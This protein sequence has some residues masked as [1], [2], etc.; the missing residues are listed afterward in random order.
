MVIFAQKSPFLIVYN[1]IATWAKSFAHALKNLRNSGSIILKK[2]KYKTILFTKH[3]FCS[4][5]TG[6]RAH[7]NRKAC[8]PKI[9]L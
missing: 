5:V 6:N 2:R 3:Y 8:T 7:F 9:R 4:T 1:K